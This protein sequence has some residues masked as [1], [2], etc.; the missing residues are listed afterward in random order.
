LQTKEKITA[1]ENALA[2]G[3]L[4]LS[5]MLPLERK[6]LVTVGL[7]IAKERVARRVARWTLGSLAITTALPLRLRSVLALVKS[8][9]NGSHSNDS[10][11]LIKKRIL[12]LGFWLE[13]DNIHR[14]ADFRFDNSFHAK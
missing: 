2:D 13:S 4:V 8:R 5:D 6:M 1:T 11:S 9:T 7:A 14:R 3:A 10:P 12:Q